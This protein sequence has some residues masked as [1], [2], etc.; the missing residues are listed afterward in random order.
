[1]SAKN[2]ASSEDVLVA[3]LIALMESSDLPPWRKPWTAKGGEHRSLIT[4]KPYRGSNPLLLELGL[5]MRGS[6]LPL[7]CGASQA[8]QRGWCPKKGSR[9][10][11][12]LR[13]QLNQRERTD[14]DGKPV[15]DGNGD[16]V[17]AAWVSYRPVCIF[18]VSDLKGMTEESQATLDSRIAE[19]TVA[20]PTVDTSTRLEAAESHLEQWPVPVMWGGSTLA[21]YAPHL[22]SISMPLKQA[23]HSREAMC[24]TWLHEQAHS[25][26]H[27][28]RLNRPL[29]HRFGSAGYA[30]EELIA[31]LASVLG[32]YRLNI[33]CELMQHAAYLKS[34]VKGLKAGGAKELFK[35][36]SEARQAADLIAPEPDVVP[37]L[38][39]IAACDAA[40]DEQPWLS[41]ACQ[42][43]V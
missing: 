4:G 41:P 22:D 2:K 37:E 1:M 25:T 23:F 27:S 13:P 31:E 18:N 36:L 43:L 14:A 12:I 16:A 7:W 39:S 24:S 11:R 17:V 42:A 19:E 32:C 3:D 33:G 10:V 21:F 35:V 28:S 6:S 34:W 30:R 9:A 20:V 15:L 5:L 29:I 8:K 38:N 26:G 40:D